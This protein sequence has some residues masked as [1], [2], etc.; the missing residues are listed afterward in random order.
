MAETTV[1]G[2]WGPNVWWNPFAQDRGWTEVITG[3]KY[4]GEAL[5]N[6]AWESVPGIYESPNQPKSST[7]TGGSVLGTSDGNGGSTGAYGQSRVGGTTQPSGPGDSELTALKKIENPN[8]AQQTRIQ[9]LEEQLRQSAQ[10]SRQ[11]TLDA[12]QSRLNESRRLAGEKRDRA[13]SM[14]DEVLGYVDTRYPELISRAEARRGDALTD[15]TKQESTMN[16]LYAKAAAQARRRS[17]SAALQNRMMARAGNRLGSSFYDQIVAQN[18]ENLGSTL[19]ESDK[20]RLDKLSSIGT[21]RTRTNRYFDETIDDL[22][23]TRDQAR[24]TAYRD[25]ND[26]ISTA[27]ALDR[28]GVLD[29][30]ESVAQADANLRSRLDQID[31]WAANIAAQRDLLGNRGSEADA[32]IK[33]FAYTPEYNDTQARTTGYNA[34]QG[35]T[36]GIMGTMSTMGS[37]AASTLAN[38]LALSQQKKKPYLYA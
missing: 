24:N 37:D 28:A 25:Y 36:P 19:A 4:G 15:F 16:D 33:S 23:T 14:L 11:S 13:K 29:F 21:E 2:T 38:I 20:E 22:E 5:N 30:G 1:P 32:T 3:G 31:T 18:R 34:L 35:M 6:P 17:E 9:E 27:D 12:I 26:A 7:E 10:S 8:P